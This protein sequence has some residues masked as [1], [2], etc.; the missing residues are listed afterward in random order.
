MQKKMQLLDLEHW[1]VNDLLIKVDR[2]L[3]AHGIEGRV[4][5]LDKEIA[6]F[7]FHL[8]DNLKIQR[9]LG[10]WIIRLWLN[11]FFPETQPFTKK[12]GFSVPIG[13]WIAQSGSRLANLVS[14]QAGVKS[15]CKK[16]VVLKIFNYLL[17]FKK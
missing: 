2:C 4:P 12:S 1:L 11:K 3:M 9:R 5:F 10:K 13:N 17:I 6:S 16:E 8:P 14:D 7:L 15:F